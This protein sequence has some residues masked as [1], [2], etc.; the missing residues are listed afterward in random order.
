[1][2]GITI[3]LMALLAIGCSPN[4]RTTHVLPENKEKRI[5]LPI[6]IAAENLVA[7][8]SACKS[9]TS[10]HASHFAERSSITVGWRPLDGMGFTSITLYADGDGARIP[11]PLG[12][13]S[14]DDM[15]KLER[16]AVK[17]ATC[18]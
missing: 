13:V 12:A 2:R 5:A 3:G 15:D 4:Q 7:G 17:G 11:L 9:P 10:L 16:W 14:Q 18:G 8:L 1:M 6:K